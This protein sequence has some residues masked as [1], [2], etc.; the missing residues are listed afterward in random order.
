MKFALFLLVSVSSVYSFGQ[1]LTVSHFKNKKMLY[2]DIDLSK[3]T[4]EH[5]ETKHPDDV[6]ANQPPQK[7]SGVNLQEILK[8]AKIRPNDS[9]EVTIIGAD[10]YLAEFKFSDF[11]SGTPIF[12]YILNEQKISEKKG[13]I[14]T[15]FPSASKFSTTSAVWVWNIKS[16]HIGPTKPLVTFSYENTQKTINL[17]EIKSKTNASLVL[18][19]HPPGKH[20]ND[21][22]E[23]RMDLS[24]VR[25]KELINVSGKGLSIETIF[26]TKTLLPSEVPDYYMI[27]G[28]K[29]SIPRHLG[30]PIQICQENDLKSCLFFA[31]NIT[32]KA[33]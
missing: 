5:I 10:K 15:I 24:K 13:G 17:S 19:A 11:K 33:N 4:T 28:R 9:D 12:A 2:Q 22:D 32:L 3:L 23:F 26:E 31:D 29:E 21:R 27:F 20:L 8:T 1:S 25:L 16:I 14:H 30:G 7:W 18:I 6:Y